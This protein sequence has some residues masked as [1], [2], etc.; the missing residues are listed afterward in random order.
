MAADKLCEQGRFGQKTGAGWYRYE[1]GNR[2][3]LPDPV[4]AEL[5]DAWRK[6][7]G[8]TARKVSD[9]E[10][11]ERCIFALVNEGAKILADGIAQRA[12]DIDTVY[13]NGYGFPRFRGGPMLYAGEVGLP[14]VVRALRRIAAE[15]PQDA[16]MWTPAPLLV[17]LAEEGRTFS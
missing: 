16:D 5:L 7:R 8:L 14:N 9:A 15:S 13:L 2:N 1:A 6:E 11:V 17:Q 3:A 4:V 10:V 12:S